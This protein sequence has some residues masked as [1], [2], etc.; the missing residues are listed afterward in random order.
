MNQTLSREHLEW[1]GARGISE[2]TAIRF[3]LFTS[4]QQSNGR[5]LAV[6]FV[7]GGKVINHKYRGP[8]KKFWMDKD[9][10]MTFW[11][12]EALSRSELKNA[13][14]LVVEGEM[15]GLAAVEAG[16]ER[17]VSVPNGAESNLD[18]MAS[19]WEI[20]K[21]AAFVILC[22]DGDEPGQKL[23]EEL[24]RRFGP[25]RC[26]W[27]K[28]PD[29]LKDINDVLMHFGA[30]GVHELIDGAKPYPVK[31]LYKLSDYPDSGPLRTFS[32]GWPELDAFYC[33][34][35]GTLCVVTG[36]PG[37][38]KSKFTIAL[39]K[40][41]LAIN[42]HR[43]A[44]GSF[45]MPVMPYLRNEL[46]LHLRNITKNAA[47]ADAWIEDRMSFIDQNL[48]A[49]DDDPDLDWLLG[50]ADAAIIRDDIKWVLIDPWNQVDDSR[51]RN[52]TEEQAQR[53][54]IRKLQRFAKSRNAGVIV[55][56]HPTKAVNMPTGKIREPNLYDISGS[57]HW[58]NGCDHGIIL[59]RDKRLE[60]MKVA[61][62]KARFFGTGR[63]GE[64]WMKWRQDLG[65]YTACDAPSAYD[66]H[67]PE[68]LEE[69]A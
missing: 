44:I 11:N 53:K 64:M 32:T 50:L 47:D 4:T 19:C 46:R 10:E 59:D 16:Y 42:D 12:F 23:N 9:A 61:V 63:E 25:A 40:N 6:P 67:R 58:Y 56:A 8:G 60:V 45:E 43:A 41:L 13:P 20:L 51:E 49:E 31:G 66:N 15:D 22:G 38:G 68:K 18:F 48:M 28:Y 27:L 39:L 52:E 37:T 57:A 33:P 65:V 14:L 1:L 7:K 24:A 3:G 30:D 54:Q 21:S 69:A 2:K 55:V 5:A 35:P 29:G 36:V 26:S 17:V 34:T 62:K